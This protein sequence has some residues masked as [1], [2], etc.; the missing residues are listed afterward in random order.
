MA[1]APLDCVGELQTEGNQGTPG[2]GKGL[3][4]AAALRTQQCGPPRTFLRHGPQLQQSVQPSPQEPR[5]GGQSQ[6]PLASAC[7]MSSPCRFFR[8][9]LLRHGGGAE[10]KLRAGSEAAA[11]WGRGGSEAKGRQ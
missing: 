9:I 10:M 7:A 2:R 4:V 8:H 5:Q 3:R 11:A 1:G 6:Q